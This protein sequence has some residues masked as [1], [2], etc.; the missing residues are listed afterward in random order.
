[1]LEIVPQDHCTQVE[2][3]VLGG[4]YIPLAPVVDEPNGQSGYFYT[5]L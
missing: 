4:E 5:A 1:M 3:P 2:T